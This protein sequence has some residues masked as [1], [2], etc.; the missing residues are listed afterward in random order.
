MTHSGVE[1]QNPLVRR[2][3]PWVL[4][5]VLTIGVGGFAALGQVQSTS[6]VTP[7]AWV[8]NVITA[9]TAAGSA[10]LRFVTVTTSADAS[11]DQTTT[12][13]GEIDFGNGNFSVTQF[14]RQ[15]GSESLNGGPVQ[16]LEETWGEHTIA[17]GQT[18]YHRL[19]L[20]LSAPVPATGSLSAWSRS[21]F[22]RQVHQA[23]G[24]DAAIG[25]EDAVAGLASIAP[26]G[27]VRELGPGSVGGVATTRYLITARPLY[28]C[29]KHGKTVTLHLVPATTVWIDGDGR[30]LRARVSDYNKGGPVHVPAGPSGSGGSSVTVPSSTTVST[31]TFSAFGAPVH[32]EAPRTNGT[33]GG[34]FSIALLQS[35]ARTTPCGR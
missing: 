4:L 30:L 22:P 3:V 7:A 14:Y 5:A 24:L 11:Q 2:F 28:L 27:A 16:Q 13:N 8:H 32:V 20:P 34:G 26:V 19:V 6:G 10:H 29:G 12:G 25:A 17:V 33:G 15:H 23:F 1:R 9:T 21:H 31:L 18:V 35:K